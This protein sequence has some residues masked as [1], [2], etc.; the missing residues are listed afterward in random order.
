MKQRKAGS[1]KLLNVLVA[2]AVALS[3][4]SIVMAA[5]VEPVQVGLIAP[6]SGIYARY[7]QVMRMGA[8]M[9]I[10]DINAQ[11]VLSRLEAQS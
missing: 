4:V 3:Q 2:G 8:D 11:G 5:D 7:G 1:N 6:M 10:T 9:A